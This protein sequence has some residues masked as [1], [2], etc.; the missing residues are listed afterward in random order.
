MDGVS[1]VDRTLAVN[2]ANLSTMATALLERMYYCKVDGKFVSPTDPGTGHVFKELK[3]FR[4]KLCRMLGRYSK[5]VSTNSFVLMYRSRKRAI[6]EAAGERFEIFGV[7]HRDANCSMFVKLEKV[8]P[9]KAPRCIQPRSTVYNVAVGRY[10][11]PIEHKVYEVIADVF[12]SSTPVVMKGLNVEGVGVSLASKWDEFVAPVAVG[13][14]ATKFDMH[15]STSMLKW[16]HSV[17]AHMFNNDKELGKLLSWQLNNSGKAYA[18]DG[19]L[20]YHVRGRRFSGDMNTALGNCLIMCGMIYS[21]ARRQGVRIEL[22]N[23]GDDAVVI[24]E[25]EDLHKFNGGLKE[26]F[27]TLGFRMTVEPPV[28]ELEQVEFCQMHPVDVGGTWRMV[29]NLNSSREKDSM[30]LLRIGGET[31]FRK[32]LG[33][34]GECGLALTSGVPVMQEFYKF[35]CRNGMKSKM[36]NAVGMQT[37]FFFLSIGM[38]AKVSPVE[39]DTRLSFYKAFGL[40]PDEQVALEQYYSSLKFSWTGVETIDNLNSL[41]LSPL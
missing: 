3:T 22:A 17:Y 25:T 32:W 30:C 8:N 41:N 40:T 21:W 19:T 39:D 11:K 15:V 36:K 34:V 24:M 37:G 35:Y 26:W 5:P 23:N 13:L 31:D 20:S 10:L 12:K 29:R 14:D 28:F 16:E 33:A 6:Y 7:S 38:E 18:W 4:N 1:P 27:G 9:T 2:D